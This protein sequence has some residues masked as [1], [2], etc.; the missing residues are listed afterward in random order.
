MLERKTPSQRA[1]RSRVLQSG[2]V[3]GASQNPRALISK[4]RIKVNL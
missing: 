1:A 4:Q 3:T 2:L